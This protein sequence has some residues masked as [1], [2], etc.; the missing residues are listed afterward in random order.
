MAVAVTTGPMPRCTGD[1]IWHHRQATRL[2]ASSARSLASPALATE[3]RN[4]RNFQPRPPHDG[5]GP[6]SGV[7]V[8]IAARLG[9]LAC[10]SELLVVTL[11]C[12]G[13]DASHR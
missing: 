1:A 11:K 12:S 3:R 8:G 7:A 4:D 5:H 13:R 9:G 2:R 10:W 6:D